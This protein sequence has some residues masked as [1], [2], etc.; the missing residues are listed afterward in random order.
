[1]QG[2]FGFASTLLDT[3][4]KY[5][6]KCPVMI[7]SSIQATCIGRYDS[8]TLSVIGDYAFYNCENLTQ[9]EFSNVTSIGANAFA[10]CK[11]LTSVILSGSSICSLSANNAFAG[12]P[13][14]NGDG[15]IYVP[16]NLIDEYRS[17]TNWPTYFN[18]FS[19]IEN[20]VKE[21]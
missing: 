11:N 13:I 16:E 2:N 12:T 6:N 19:V 9:V 14:E 8:D 15:C 4:K 1:M 5:N 21:G 20:N 10:N 18:Q 17:A 7:S 3:L